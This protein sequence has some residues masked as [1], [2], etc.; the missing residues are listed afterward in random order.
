[1]RVRQ[2]R[3]AAILAVCVLAAGCGSSTPTPSP[4][5]GPSETPAVT[6]PS[7]EPTAAPPTP[8]SEALIAAA[9]ADGSIT[10]EQSLLYRALA[11]FDSPGLPAEFRS[12]VR[13]MEAAG[14][15]L[16]DIDVAESTLSAATL[17]KLA[18][19]RVRP[20][21]PTS[22]YNQPSPRAQVNA[23]GAAAIAPVAQSG[24]AALTDTTPAWTSQPAAGGK[25]RVWVKTSASA[26]ADLARYATLVSQV[27]AAYPGIFTYPEPDQPNQ[28]SAAINP[29]SMIDIYFVSTTEIDPRDTDCAKDPTLDGCSL[30]P[31]VDGYG[32]RTGPYHG[33][34]SS[35]Y[36]VV[37]ASTDDDKTIDTIAHEL[38]HNAQ[39]AYDM[40]ESS[41]LMESTATWVAYKVDLKLGITPAYQYAW[42][43]SLFARLDRTLTREDDGNAYASWLYFQFAAMEEGN[44]VVTNIWKA[45][46]AEGEQGYKAVDQ[47][48]SF[49]GHFD[50]YAVRDW[51]QD[52]IEP[53]YKSADSTFPGREP[54][55]RNGLKTL[56]GGREDT[57]DANLPPLA[58]AYFEYD[59]PASA[60]DVTFD[61]R[62]S[63]SADARV[64][65]IPKIG[66][67]WQEPQDW[68]GVSEMKF[69]RDIA[70][71]DVKTIVLVVSNV[72]SSD[73]L[74]VPDGPVMKS[75]TAG[76]SGW[77]GTMTATETWELEGGHG[78]ATSTFK[79]LWV[80]EEQGDARCNPLSDD[81]CV[82]YRPTGSITW[83]W[84]SHHA[85]PKCDEATSGSL[86]ANTDERH[87]QQL[88]Y[89][90]PVGDDKLRYWGQGFFIVTGLTCGNLITTSNYPP[91]FFDI[92][93]DAG[94]TNGP[95]GTGGDCYNRDWQIDLKANTISGSCAAY[96][97]EHATLSF[98]WHLTRVGPAS[99]N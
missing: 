37:A 80:L 76:C 15:L 70:E 65:A 33:N 61:N 66:E 49:A 32:P 77:A 23:I 2:G 93:E 41:W 36:L 14:D 56:E 12:P 97:Y 81:K 62:L 50:D 22:I 60:R 5:S 54:R 86:A 63:G 71:Q 19:Y 79:G 72:N 4:G 83:T 39:F 92:S 58:T 17:E 24:A 29:D 68:T 84:D 3:V 69:C 42:L 51:N 59:F 40:D 78:T 10:K 98:E 85:L 13:D 43:R 82:L 26:T 35:G 25:A 44:D 16:R 1:V 8:T 75:G 38:A 45:A 99:T 53:L 9:L 31:R 34:K 11:L 89:F 47:V 6:E 90:A 52:P 57:L 28:P 96:K 18:P 91:G 27:W 48:F 20:N 64:W 74:N 94:A 88:L 67:T 73:G 30:G 55:I 95:D 46:A 7:P 21:D 87:D